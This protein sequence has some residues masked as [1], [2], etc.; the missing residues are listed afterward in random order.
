[1]FAAQYGYPGQGPPV[2]PTEDKAPLFIGL[3][4]PE[5]LLIDTDYVQSGFIWVLDKGVLIVDGALLDLSGHLIC[6]GGGKVFLLNGAILNFNQFYVG[7]YYLW[8]TDSSRFEAYD[9][10]VSANGTMHYVYLEKKSTYIAKRTRFPDWTFRQ[11]YNRATLILEDV[12]HVGDIRLEDSCYIHITRCDT[13]MPWLQL[14]GGS[15]VDVAFPEPEYV[16]HYEF[17]DATPGVDGIGYTVI[18]DTSWRCWW[19]IAAWPSCSATIRNSELRGSAVGLSGADTH[20]VY[21]IYDFKEHTDLRVPL[22]DRYLR[23]V[24]TYIWWW[25]WKPMGK[26]VFYMDSCMFSELVGKD[27][28]ETYATRSIC[29]GATIHLGS[30]G[31]S[32]VQFADG[33]VWSF[34]AS[35]QRSTL[36]LENTYV[37]PLWPYQVFNIAHSHSHMLCINSRFEVQPFALDTAI[38]IFSAIDTLDTLAPGSL[39][40]VTGSAWISAGPQNPVR[41][42]NYRLYWAWDE[43]PSWNLI[44]D[45][46]GEVHSDTLGFWNTLGLPPGDY[47]LRLTVWD[48]AGDS[49]SAFIDVVLASMRTGEREGSAG[50]SLQIFQEHDGLRVRFSGPRSS[51]IRLEAYD[52]TGRKVAILFDGEPK[53]GE[54]GVLFRPGP[55]V[56]VLVLSGND[57]FIKRAVAIR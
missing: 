11:V 17:S 4:G 34:V 57:G 14:P 56:Y 37:V 40:P 22:T 48:D 42:K 21:G 29:D 49:L 50:L 30:E 6:T 54:E 24:N 26:T 15:V 45:S 33:Q 55:G 27:S 38:V 52:M 12:Y 28:S 35:W 10:E 43:N 25:N 3:G 51:P 47:D 18:I 13:L 23:F 1:M 9:S 32:F 19:S 36:L 31:N 39:A 53:D 8:L 20:R 7:Q 5:T 16:D 46:A 44:V 41:F 2:F